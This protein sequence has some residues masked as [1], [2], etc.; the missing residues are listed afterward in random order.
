[1]NISLQDDGD[2]A[3]CEYFG[4]SRKAVA[5]CSIIDAHEDDGDEIITDT[6]V[7]L[8]CAKHHPAH[9]DYFDGGSRGVPNLDARLK[10]IA[11]KHKSELVKDT[12]PI[13]FSSVARLI[14]QTNSLDAINNIRIHRSL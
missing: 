5:E 4:C 1:M 13:E 3:M 11:Q 6:G 8:L 2:F 14:N 12:N 9:V 10:E 7:Q